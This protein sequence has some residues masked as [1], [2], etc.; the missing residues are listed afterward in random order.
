MK[1]ETYF[2]TKCT[3]STSFV[4]WYGIVKRCT[5]LSQKYKRVSTAFF[6]DATTIF[7]P[8][9]QVEK[10]CDLSNHHACSDWLEG[11]AV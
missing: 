7:L 10:L 2:D 8:T 9:V 3:R 5:H 6:D 4:K 1:T 11:P